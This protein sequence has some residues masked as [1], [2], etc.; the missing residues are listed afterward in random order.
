MNL[1]PKWTQMM[2]IFGTKCFTTIL[3]LVLQFNY[4]LIV[5]H[6]IKLYRLLTL[7]IRN[8]LRTFLL[9]L[10][11]TFVDYCLLLMTLVNVMHLCSACNR[12]TINFYMM[13]MMMH[14][15]IS[16]KNKHSFWLHSWFQ[17]ACIYILSM[18]VWTV[19]PKS[20]FGCKFQLI[21]CYTMLTEKSPATNLPFTRT[22]TIIKPFSSPDVSF[23][24]FSFQ[25]NTV[26]AAVAK[27]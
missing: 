23:W 26:T 24:C 10:L 5:L 12:C 4:F 3:V 11:L 2:P 25:A 21:L 27:N 20:T 7:S 14:T 22:Q 6:I 17:T 18:Y 13:M 19:F 9:V 8:T 16:C 1:M 15:I